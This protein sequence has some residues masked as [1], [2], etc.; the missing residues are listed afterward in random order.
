MTKGESA[1][2]SQEPDNADRM[3]PGK[4]ARFYSKLEG[5]RGFQWRNNMVCFMELPLI[6]IKYLKYLK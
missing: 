1:E 6:F 5:T 2:R 3:R 4:T